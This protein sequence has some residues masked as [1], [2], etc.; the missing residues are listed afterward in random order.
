MESQQIFFTE[1]LINSLLSTKTI[2]IYLIVLQQEKFLRFSVE[3]ISQ[4][5]TVD[6]IFQKISKDLYSLDFSKKT[7]QP[8]LM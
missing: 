8:L 1:L 5:I 7:Q 2:K 6:S 4:Q 3:C